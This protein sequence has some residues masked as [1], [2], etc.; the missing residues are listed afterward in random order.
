MLEEP[1]PDL[2]DLL[3]MTGEAGLR[4]SEINASE[5]SAGNLSLFAAWPIDPRRRFPNVEP[6]RLPVPAP[7]LAGGSMLM[8]GSGRRLREI[9]REPAYHL[10]FIT[11]DPGGETGKL[12]TAPGKR[13]TRLSV[14]LNSHIAIHNDQVQRTGTNFHAVVHA[15]PRYLTFLSHV[16]QYRDQTFFNRHLLRW[17]PEMIYNFPEGVGVV[18][19]YVPG[20]TELMEATVEALR[21]H[22]MVLWCKH[23]VLARSDISIKRAADRIEYTEAAAQFEYMDL[24]NHRIADGLS[25]E[26]VHLISERWNVN[27]TIF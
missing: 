18:P 14:E 7:H 2:D 13:F 8:S 16:P 9:I 10:G 11:I 27:Q 24:S 4:I 21:V 26:E 17:Q 20:S 5:G 23:G 3:E 22:R 19:F 6:I 1:Y 15:Q 25:E 12:Y